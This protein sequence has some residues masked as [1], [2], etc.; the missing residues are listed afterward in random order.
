MGREYVYPSILS[1]QSTVTK[2]GKMWLALQQNRLA[3]MIQ[4][5][6]NKIG[7]QT[8]SKFQ[9]ILC[10]LMTSPQELGFIRDL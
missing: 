2:V 3:D 6:K 10:K 4:K 8:G 5:L 1:K 7:L 9:V